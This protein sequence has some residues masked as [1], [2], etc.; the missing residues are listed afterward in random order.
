MSTVR[1]RFA[2]VFSE[3]PS[4]SPSR[5]GTPDVGEEVQLVPV[6]KLKKLTTAKKSKRKSWLIFGLGGLFGLVVAVF[7]AN[8]HDVIKL[9]GLLDVHLDSLMDAIP[10]GI[11]RDA[12][13]LSVRTGTLADSCVL[14]VEES[15]ARSCKLRQLFSRTS[16]PVAGHPRPSSGNNDSWGHI[17]RPRVLGHRA[18]VPPILPQTAMGFVVNDARSCARSNILEEAHYVGQNDWPGST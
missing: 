3:T 12:K 18:K 2:T 14:I 9:E 17:H 7:F 5:D 1:H 16:P 13:D 6:S 15:R 8:Q 4:P 11:V 10:A